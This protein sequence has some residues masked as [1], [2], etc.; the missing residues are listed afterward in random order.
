[1]SLVIDVHVHVGASSTLQVAGG[2]EDVIR[3][4][5]DNEI[6]QSIISPIPGYVTSRG[7]VDSAEHNDNMAMAVKKWPDRLPRGLGVIEPRHGKAALPEVDRVLGDLGLHGLMFHNDFNGVTVDDP[8]MFAIIERAAKYR[9]IVIM[10]HTAQQS[11]IESPFHLMVLAEAFPE[12]TFLDAH[13]IMLPTQLS[14]TALVARKCP[15]VYF[16]TCLTYHHLWPI[17]KAVKEIGAD[18]LLFGSDN[19]Y[20]T[21][22]VDKVIVEWADISDEDKDKIF[23]QNAKKLFSL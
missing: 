12:V 23:H 18:R 5:D 14:A 6:D 9:D 11:M 2:P 8:R 13:P 19:P 21:K 3:I 15:N 1:M 16:D 7:I 20:F 4:M 22:C 17:E 10:I